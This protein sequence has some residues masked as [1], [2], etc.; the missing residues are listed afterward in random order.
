MA[1]ALNQA[2]A[3]GLLGDS[4]QSVAVVGTAI[5]IAGF[6]NIVVVVAFLFILVREARRML[7]ASLDKDG[8]GKVTF[9][10]IGAAL[11]SVVVQTL[12]PQTSTFSPLSRAGSGPGPTG[13]GGT[14]GS[15]A[16]RAASVV[17]PVP[18]P[19]TAPALALA[20]SVAPSP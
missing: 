3:P 19:T 13:T 5:G 12:L 17:A 2:M 15:A 4:S 6:L 8:K 9:A 11:G 7:V 14:G 20:P 16:R 1:P 10:D 18:A